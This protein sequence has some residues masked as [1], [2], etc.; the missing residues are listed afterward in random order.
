MTQANGYDIPNMGGSTIANRLTATLIE[1]MRNG[2]YAECERLPAEG[3]LAAIYGVS[4][5]V[6]R[7]VLANLEREGFVARGRGVGTSINK[8]IVRLDNRLDLKL[9]YMEFV[10]SLGARPSVD[11]VVL[12]EEP[13]GAYIA[14]C[15]ALGV[16][17][18]LIVCQKR[19]LASGVPVIFSED[20]IP[21]H[22]FK[23]RDYKNYDWGRPVYDIL[24]E[25]CG[26]TVDTDIARIS[27]VAATGV[28]QRELEVPDGTAMFLIDELGSYRLQYPIVQT[29]AYYSD[30][31]DFTILRK[32]L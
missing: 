32:K 25:C 20:R 14:E 12:S 27:P 23:A 29:Y 28:A 31:F 6:I 21:L 19:V 18:P 22:F 15:L 17:T 5:S 4:R 1:A 9:E 3:E 24:E 26:V 11:H 13:A 2:Q 7:D 16:G 10:S 30:F 8:Q